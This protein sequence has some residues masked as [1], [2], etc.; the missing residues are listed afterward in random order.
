MIQKLLVVSKPVADD[1]SANPLLRGIPNPTTDEELIRLVAHD[2]FRDPQWLRGANARRLPD[3][4][5]SVFVPTPASLR[6]AQT[7]FDV[8][9]NGYDRRNPNEAG[10][11]ANFYQPQDGVSFGEAGPTFTDGVAI[12]GITGLGKSHRVCRVLSVIPQTIRHD[13]LGGHLTGI[14]QIVWIYIDMN[15]ATGLEALLLELLEKIDEL[16]GTQEY[17]RQYTTSRV[18]IDRLINTLIR[19]LKTHFCG[20]LVLDEVQRLNFGLKKAS[21]RVRNL[22]LKLLNAGI[23]VVLVGNPMGLQFNEKDGFSAQLIRRL[24]ANSPVRLDPADSPMDEEWQTLVRGLWRCQILPERSPLTA[25]HFNL[26]YRYTG[27]FPKC[28]A[29]LLAYSQQQALAVGATQLT[30]DLIEQA[31]KSSSMLNEMR[32]LIDAFVN[33]DALRLRTFNDVDTDYYKN[34]WRPENDCWQVGPISSPSPTTSGKKTQQDVLSQEQSR[35]KAQRT[36]AKNKTNKDP[37]SSGAQRDYFLQ[38]ID[39]IIKCNRK[40]EIAQEAV[41]PPTRSGGREPGRGGPAR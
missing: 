7:I 12:A 36:A 32:P 29:H 38:E 9:H 33:R 13:N 30:L 1:T 20:M 11:W 21:E 16:L 39:S 24:K 22:M 18:S 17:R 19:A 3:L 15:T 28:L 26:L 10:V 27:G 25:T 5:Q 2:P 4:L 14:T 40:D 35:A 41:T 37:A 34:K 6:L 31:A 8:L 23:P